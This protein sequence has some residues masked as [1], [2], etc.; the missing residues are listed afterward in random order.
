[1]I[2]LLS[3]YCNDNC[4]YD[5]FYLL[6]SASLLYSSQRDGPISYSFHNAVL[7][8]SCWHRLTA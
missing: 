5:G 6:I 3:Y 7:H 8:S 1:M 4:V 2:Y